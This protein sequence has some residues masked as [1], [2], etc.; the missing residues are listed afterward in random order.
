MGGVVSV[1]GACASADRS[2]AWPAPW[3]APPAAFGAVF[4]A[5]SFWVVFSAACRWLAAAAGLAAALSPGAAAAQT[6]AAQDAPTLAEIQIL[7]EIHVIATAPVA[8][9]PRRPAPAAA[10]SGAVAAPATAAAPAAEPGA[11][12]RDKIPSNVQVLSA[13]DFD[14]ATAPDLLGRHGAGLA[15][16][17]ARRSD[18]QSV[19]ARPQLPRLRRLAGDR[20]AAG[21][22]RV[23]ERRAHQ[24]GVRR[25]RQLGL[26]PG[27]RHQPDDA[28]AQQSGLRAQRD[29]RRAGVRDE[30]RL[31][32]SRRRKR[33]DGRLLWPD[34]RDRAGRRPERQFVRLHHRRRHR[35]RRLAR[36][37]AVA[38]APPLCRSRRPRRDDRVSREL[39]RR[40]RTISA[41]PPRR[42]SRCSTRTGRASTPCRKRRRTNWRS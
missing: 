3:P 19:P 31:H 36:G 25:H 40:R 38:A 12:D 20:H 10:G 1:G 35:R 17:S 28:G 34:R 4:R 9:P 13:A 7:P 16:R 14:H 37:F 5:T 21:P 41:P 15:R 27:K 26:H 33:R 8:P 39:H 23:S 18:R 32:L 22:R 2:T 42:R 29:R 24:R 11:V 6:A 30:E